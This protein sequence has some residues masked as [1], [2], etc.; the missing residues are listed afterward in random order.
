MATALPSMKTPT[1][2]P[3]VAGLRAAVD[4]WRRE[5][6]RVGLVPTMGALHPGHLSLVA[7]AQARAQRVI[8]SVFVNPTQ[9]APHEDFDRYPRD[10]DRDLAQ[11]DEQGLT[12]IV[13]APGVSELYSRGFATK[14]EIA[15]P[16]LGLESDFRP[17]S[18][19][20]SRLWS[21]NC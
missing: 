7:E 19:P 20:A 8:V 2:I 4:N 17:H 13:F 16:A 11:L 6:S 9:F 12:D 3:T 15:G 18:L 21:P 14:I 10:L 5:G 1:V